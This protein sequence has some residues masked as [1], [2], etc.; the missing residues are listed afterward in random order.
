VSALRLVAAA[1][2]NGGR[3]TVR[4]DGRDIG[5]QSLNEGWNAC[6]WV[7]PSGGVGPGD[8]QVELVVD[9]Q[10]SIA[11]SSLTLTYAD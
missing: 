9:G 7:M 5:A 4:L 6:D 10:T 1:P 11:V 3:V 2:R 8:H